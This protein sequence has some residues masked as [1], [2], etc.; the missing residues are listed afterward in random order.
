MRRKLL[1]LWPFIL[2]LT[3]TLSSEVIATAAET[4]RTDETTLWRG[5]SKK[6]QSIHVHHYECPSTT[7]I[8]WNRTYGGVDGDS[9]R[10]VQQTSDGGYIVAGATR[11]FGAG[12]ADFWLFKIDCYGNVEWN[13][14]FGGPEL[15]AARSV[16]QTSDGGYIAVGVTHSFGDWLYGDCWLIK[17]D[18]N[19]DMVWNKTYGGASWEDATSVQQTSDGGYIVAGCT[20]S[21]GAGSFD[22]WL[23][24]TD[25]NGNVVWNNTYGGI[26]ADAADYVQQT[27]DGGYV[28]VGSADSFKT[29]MFDGEIWLVKT[30][31]YGNVSWSWLSG[32]PDWDF[33][34]SAQQTE[35]EGYI[36]AGTKFSS[37]DT[38]YDIWLIKIDANGTLEWDEVYARRGRSEDVAYSVQQTTDGGYV[39]AGGWGNFWIVKTDASGNME[40]NKSF[41]G[42]ES[43][44][45]YCVSQTNDGGYLAA[46][47]TESFGF[48]RDGSP[49]AWLV[50][51]FPF[52]D[53]AI[54]EVSPAS[55]V[56]PTGFSLNISVTVANHGDFVEAFNV[57][58]CANGTVVGEQE[59][60]LA[61]GESVI[62]PFSWNTSGFSLGNYTIS[63]YADPVANE[64][65]TDD[66]TYVDGAVTVRTPI[67]D[68][69][70]TNVTLSK[71]VVGKGYS[72]SIN[73]TV[74][75]Q[76]DYTETFNVTVSVNQTRTLTL[77]PDNQDIVVFTWSTTAVSYGNH[78]I[79]AYATTV[80]GELEVVD[81][82][83]VDGWVFVTIPGD[84]AGD[85]DVDIYDIV[86]MCGV[87][88]TSQSDPG[89]DPCCDIDDDGDI[90]IYDIVIAADHYGK[91]W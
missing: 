15:D 36:I 49:D 51:F 46:G 88:N 44:N 29:G 64:T 83:L 58:A 75:N 80:P 65:K 34:Y 26:D 14:T 8:E 82:M 22:Y 9:A 4:D 41:G 13:K 28:M 18:A 63:A 12:K 7:P 68:V 20:A 27:S 89:Y 74:E 90:D 76:G 5:Y 11:S 66:N 40:W 73:V 42:A 69:A 50:K 33:A 21:F 53:V 16:Q 71:A 39:I 85:Q 87:Y 72:M 6:V 43:E 79:S 48:G 62:L 17:T 54:T 38:R 23:I 52:H 1:W 77:P 61:F 10:Y 91:S 2:L 59:A 56:V 45:A 86:S 35:D 81:N 67:H 60:T 84:I 57:T 55:N 32:W 47:Y 31:E 30:D 24:K 25:A 19:G 78:T 70:V 3:S 37:Y